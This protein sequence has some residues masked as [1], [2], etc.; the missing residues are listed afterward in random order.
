MTY[1]TFNGIQ[2]C[3]DQYGFIQYGGIG[4]WF[5]QAHKELKAAILAAQ[6]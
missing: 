6:L 5:S 1:F 2:G 4:F 3:I